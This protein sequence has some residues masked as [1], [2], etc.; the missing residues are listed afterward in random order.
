MSLSFIGFFC[1]ILPRSIELCLRF[2]RGDD[3]DA[4]PGIAIALDILA[5]LSLSDRGF[6]GINTQGH[7]GA[8][9]E[10]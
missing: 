4:L 1:G 2:R 10:V 9:D 3:T 6:Q 7:G 8:A 5:L